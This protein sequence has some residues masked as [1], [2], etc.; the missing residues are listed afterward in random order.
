MTKGCNVL[1]GLGM[2]IFLPFLTFG[3]LKITTTG[4]TADLNGTIYEVFGLPSDVDIKKEL[5]AIN[6]SASDF[7]VK[8]RRTE[9]DV[10]PGTKN[11]TC[12][13]NCPIFQDAG[14]NPVLVSGQST[15]IA[16]SDTNFS[17]VAHHR[18]MGLD[19]CSWM[20]YEWVDEATELVVYAT[21][22]IKFYHSTGNCLLGLDD[23]KNNIEAS[24]APNPA[25]DNVLLTLEGMSGYNEVSI[26]I[27]DLLGKKVSSIA[28]VGPKNNLNVSE[29]KNGMYFISIMKNGSL[30]KTSKFI[31]E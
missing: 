29:F 1:I 22:D 20:K 30:I 28:Q 7:T 13:V 3:Q 16:A 5:Y 19:G 27:F 18:P 2:V 21:V 25:T 8:V 4:D 12:W 9:V 11:T 23:L 31:K 14:V 26:D 24:L 17:F 10:Q 6:Q 15:T